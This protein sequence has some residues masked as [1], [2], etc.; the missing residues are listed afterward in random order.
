MFFRHDELQGLPT[1]LDR[2]QLAVTG[3][4]QFDR[5]QYAFTI[6]GPLYKDRAWHFTAFEYRNQ[7]DVVLTGERDFN[8]RQVVNTFAPAPLND[9]LLTSRADWQA[10]SRNKLAFRYSLQDEDDITRGSLRAPIG[11]SANRQISTNNYQSFVFNWITTISPTVLNDFT[12]HENNF[13]NRIIPAGT[14]NELRFPSLQDGQNF[15][16]P[17]RTRQNRLQF[18]DN[19]SFQAHR[20][21]L[22]VGFEVQR[23]DADAVFD[24]FGSGTV[25]LTQDFGTM[26]RNGDGQINDQD[27]PVAVTIRSVAPNR[28]PTV[29][30]LDN[31]FFTWYFQD[32]WRVRPN[33]TLNFGVR[34]EFDTQ[35]IDTGFMNPL[36]PAPFGQGT[37]ESDKNNFGPRFGFNWD[38]WSDG[39]TSIHGGY[40][41]YYDRIVLEVPL[42]EELLDGRALP[43]EVRDGSNGANVARPF[44]GNIIPGAGAIGINIISP[45]MATPY[46]QQF[47]FGIEREVVRDLVVSADYLHSFGRKFIIGRPVGTVFNPV[48]GGVDGIVSLESSVGTWYDA[49]LLN[50]KKRFSHRFQFNAAYTLS[51]TFNFSND[52]QIPFQVGPLD[53]NNLRLEKGPPPGDQRHRFVFSGAFDLPY[54]FQIAPIWTMASDVPIDIQLPPDIGGTRIPQL[55]RNAG[56]RTFRTGAELNAFIQQLNSRGGVGGTPLPLVRDDLNLGDSFNSFDVRVSKSFTFGERAK[57][58]LIGEVFNLFN[59]TNILGVNNVNY[60]GFQNTLIRDSSDRANPGFLRSTAFGQPLNTAGGVFGTGGPRAVQFAVR[61]SL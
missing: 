54:G 48:V 11:S 6:G 60:S 14:G 30:C 1:T 13:I 16:V 29:C 9:L 34:Y 43:L 36:I 12:F 44:V 27:I 56:G 7:D 8:R 21:S 46:V 51:K 18:R 10:G 15:R 49:L 47:N 57:L 25:I 28:P 37:A 42:L 41:I 45:S 35:T 40:G 19:L 38:P 33:F 58:E 22:K 24:L 53:P 50:V 2:R 59:V 4:P 26:D 32:D 23:I 52:D 61:F 31:T 20:H 55:Q 17:Q 5:E 3:Q 39:K